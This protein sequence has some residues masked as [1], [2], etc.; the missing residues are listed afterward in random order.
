MAKPRATMQ[1][2]FRARPW[3]RGT[4]YTLLSSP[5][6]LHADIYAYYEGAD[7]YFVIEYREAG[8][9]HLASHWFWRDPNDGA[10]CELLAQPDAKLAPLY[11][12]T[13]TH[14]IFRPAHGALLASAQASHSASSAYTRLSVHCH[15]VRVRMR[16]TWPRGFVNHYRARTDIAER[17]GHGGKRPGAGRPSKAALAERRAREAEQALSEGRMPDWEL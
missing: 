12:D 2:A 14:D 8:M 4:I 10:L 13:H 7:V 11:W 9:Q 15:Y 5:L 6:I 16:T 17:I 1:L 3:I